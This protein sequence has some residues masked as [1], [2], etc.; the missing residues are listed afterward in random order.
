MFLLPAQQEHVELAEKYPNLH[1]TFVYSKPLGTDVLDKVKLHKKF[2]VPVH[3][4][5]GFTVYFYTILLVIVMIVFFFSRIT[6]L[7]V[8]WT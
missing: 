5:V 6:I 2:K 3:V 4:A 1:N 7:K 8:V